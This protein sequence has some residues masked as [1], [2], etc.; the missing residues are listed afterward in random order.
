MSYTLADLGTRVKG[1]RV[2]ALPDGRLASC[3]NDGT[4]RIWNTSTGACETRVNGIDP[5]SCVCA[6]PDGRIVTVS[7]STNW[8]V[9]Q[10]LVKDK[11]RLCMWY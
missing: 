8:K 2:C 5:Y 4:L 1:G 7:H 3:S 10:L 9:P 6:F 11:D